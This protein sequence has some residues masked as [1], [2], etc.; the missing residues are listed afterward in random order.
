MDS[1][2]I[3]EGS[4]MKMKRKSHT[5]KNISKKYTWLKIIYLGYTKHSYIA[6]IRSWKTEF[7]K[8]AKDF[9]TQLKIIH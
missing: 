4:V 9:N 1:I 6:L 3:K 7:R 8:W 5:R 2:R